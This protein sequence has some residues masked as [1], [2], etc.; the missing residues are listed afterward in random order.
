MVYID[1]DKESIQDQFTDVNGDIWVYKE[2]TILTEYVW[3]QNGDEAKLHYS[4]T[5]TKQSGSYRSIPEVLGHYE[6][7][8]GE[9][10]FNGFLEFHVNNVYE[11][12][13]PHKEEVTPYPGTRT[14]WPGTC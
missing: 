9:D 13:E 8:S 1:E 4:D 5:Y 2:T 14:S 10:E 11:K 12:V 7:A 6:N 3:R